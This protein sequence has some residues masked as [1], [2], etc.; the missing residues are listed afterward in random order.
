MMDAGSIQAAADGG[1]PGDSRRAM[2]AAHQKSKNFDASEAGRGADPDHLAHRFTGVHQLVGGGG[3]IIK[4]FI[5]AGLFHPVTHDDLHRAGKHIAEFFALVGVV[6]RSFTAGGHFHQDGLHA[7][8]LGGG[9]QPA[10]AAA[11]LFFILLDEDIILA[12]YD[13]FIIGLGK[14]CGQIRAQGFQYIRK[15]IQGRGGLIALQKGDKAL[16]KLAAIRQLFLCKPALQADSTDFIADL[17]RFS[18]LS[19]DKCKFKITKLLKLFY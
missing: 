17:H 19:I 18:F 11:N 8:F 14:E 15:R 13:L 1:N 10:D 2:P 5:L 7:V 16:R 12:E 6:F 9:H 4:A 3:Q